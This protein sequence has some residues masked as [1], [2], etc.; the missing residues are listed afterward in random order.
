MYWGYERPMEDEQCLGYVQ[1][2]GA[3]P[4]RG[5]NLHIHIATKIVGGGR[6]SYRMAGACLSARLAFKQLHFA[7]HSQNF[8]ILWFLH[9][10]RT[11]R[12]NLP[13]TPRYQQP[14]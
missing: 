12:L 7:L 14:P 13:S 9:T 1:T 10:F 3:E 5:G 6:R 2:I 4:Q 11:L 8:Y